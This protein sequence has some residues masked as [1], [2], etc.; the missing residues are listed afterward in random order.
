MAVLYTLG[1][2]FLKI[3]L[4]LARETLAVPY[5]EEEEV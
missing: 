4:L 3:S 2:I 5:G 1:P